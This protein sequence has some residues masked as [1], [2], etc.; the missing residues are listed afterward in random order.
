MKIERLIPEQLPDAKSLLQKNNLPTEDI[1]PNTHLFG[2]YDGDKLVGMAGLELY[3]NHALVRSVCVEQS[4]RSKGMAELL[5]AHIENYAKQNGADSLYLLTTTAENY[6]K[7]KGFIKTNR[8]EVPQ[9]I[10]QTSEF[11]TVCPSSAT[12]MMKNLL[13]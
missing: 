2:T 10:M 13:P 5:T 7:R 11:S 12:V 1:N 6:F 3:G 9:A 8:S 4:Y